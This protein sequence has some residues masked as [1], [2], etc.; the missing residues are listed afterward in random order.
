MQPFPA[1]DFSYLGQF[2]GPFDFLLK[3]DFW[4]GLYVGLRW[5]GIGLILLLLVSFVYLVFQVWPFRM[6]WRV[7]A[8]F[9]A[10]RA[11]RQRYALEDTQ[12]IMT[13]KKWGEVIR[14]VE[15][16]TAGF[17]LAVIEADVLLEHTLGR[18]GIA[19]K[20]IAER[21][22]S[23]APDEVSDINAVWEAHALRNRIAHEP[24]FEPTREEVT[25]AL[26]AYKKALEELDAL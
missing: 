2:L 18:I 19:G 11:P 16:G 14:R 4:V 1:F 12:K 25:R 23:L 21:L 26:A 3:S 7:R 13:R 24:G 9:Q 15:M 5:V 20:N 10:Y 17:A 6:R 8:G 22:R